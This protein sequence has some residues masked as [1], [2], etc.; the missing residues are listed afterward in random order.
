MVESHVWSAI[1]E[2]S[3]TKL[4]QNATNFKYKRII[5]DN[6]DQTMQRAVRCDEQEMKREKN[7]AQ[8]NSSK[9]HWIQIF[10]LEDGSEWIREREIKN[11]KKPTTEP[12]TSLSYSYSNWNSLP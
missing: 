8:T 9:I 11:T 2:I 3:H 1:G 5:I 6:R 10:V 12:F 4:K 7:D